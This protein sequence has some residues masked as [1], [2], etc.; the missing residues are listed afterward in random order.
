L[1]QDREYGYKNSNSMADGEL[2]A[3]NIILNCDNEC[4]YSVL[5]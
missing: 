4:F 1:V 5:D 2:L 3:V